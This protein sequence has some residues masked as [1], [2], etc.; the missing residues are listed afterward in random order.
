MLCGVIV[1]CVIWCDLILQ[2]HQKPKW[3]GRLVLQAPT[4][5]LPLFTQPTPFKGKRGETGRRALARS[6]TP[7]PVSTGVETIATHYAEPWVREPPRGWTANAPHWHHP[8]RPSSYS[9]PQQCRPG[10]GYTPR[11]CPTR[12]ASARGGLFSR[13]YLSFRCD[14]GFKKATANLPP[15]SPTPQKK[16]AKIGGYM[17][18]ILLRFCCDSAASSANCYIWHRFC[19]AS[20]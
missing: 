9:R 13:P 7:K 5:P 12:P 11:T 14:D 10:R 15:P 19:C 6:Y 8:P 17:K 3:W 4:P 16:N 20:V 2:R 1:L 18:Q